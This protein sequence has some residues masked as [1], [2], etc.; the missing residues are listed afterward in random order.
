MTN[1][2]LRLK[3][4]QHGAGTRTLLPPQYFDPNAPS[5]H[6]KCGSPELVPSNNAYGPTSAVSHGI[7]TGKSFPG[8]YGPNLAP[9]PNS[10][11]VQTGGSSP[12]D[13]IVNPFTNRKVNLFSKKGKAILKMYINQ[14]N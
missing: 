9:Y 3:K 8:M 2:K 1:K 10:S 4:S 11:G 12:Y 13:Y 7:P 14:I 5:H 6:Y